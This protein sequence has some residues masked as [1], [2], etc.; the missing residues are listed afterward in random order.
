[1]A[2]DFGLAYYRY[3]YLLTLIWNITDI[4]FLFPTKHYISDNVYQNNSRHRVETPVVNINILYHI[5]LILTCGGIVTLCLPNLSYFGTILQFQSSF[6]WKEDLLSPQCNISCHVVQPWRRF[7]NHK[8][9]KA[10]LHPDLFLTDFFKK[11]LLS[12]SEN[13]RKVCVLIHTVTVVF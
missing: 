12:V 11:F 1:M 6:P 7:T 3:N 5:S 2:R 10:C 9:F 4:Y 8:N 13:D